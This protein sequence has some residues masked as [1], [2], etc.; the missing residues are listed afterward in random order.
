VVA[1]GRWPDQ[2][3]LFAQRTDRKVLLPVQGKLV[4]KVKHRRAA[5]GTSNLQE[6]TYERLGF[7]ACS[8]VAVENALYLAD[9][10]ITRT[11]RVMGHRHIAE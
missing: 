8:W 6:F 2:I 9:Q 7:E 4:N 3:A 1:E 10:R 5:L 11:L